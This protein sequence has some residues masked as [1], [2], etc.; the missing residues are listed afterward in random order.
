M[1]FN[2]LLFI[3]FGEILSGLYFDVNFYVFN[4]DTKQEKVVFKQ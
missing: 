4:V 2:H 1:D 3:D